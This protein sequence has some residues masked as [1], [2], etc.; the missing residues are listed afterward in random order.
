MEID[1]KFLKQYEDLIHKASLVLSIDEGLYNKLKEKREFGIGKYKEESFQISKENAINVDIKK[2]AKE[3]VID[4]LNYLL[5]MA[6]VRHLN[7]ESLLSRDLDDAIVMAK[8]I[9][10]IIDDIRLE[11]PN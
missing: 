8:R 11:Y 1:K 4:L 10:S 5:H 7:K 9:Y 2:H 3:E 6:V